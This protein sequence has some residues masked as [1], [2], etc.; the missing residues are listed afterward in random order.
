MSGF[1]EKLTAS[2]RSS[3]SMLCVGLDPDPSRLPAVVS[4][5]PT[6]V[7]EFNRQIVDATI[8]LVCAYKP[9][10]A[11]YSAFG[12]ESELEQTIDYIKSLNPEIP[13]ILDAKRGDIGS[14]AEMYAREAFERYGADAVTVNPYMGGDTLEPFLKYSDRGV[15]VLCHTSNPGSGEFQD[16]ESEGRALYMA[17]AERASTAWNGNENVALVVGATYPGMLGEVRKQVGNMPILV[18][19]IGTQGGDIEQVLD[20][21][22]ADNGSGLVLNVARSII[23]AGNDQDFAMAAREKAGLFLSA[24]EQA[25][26]NQS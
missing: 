4:S 15:V 12:R 17:V 25:R 16:M 22:L 1:Y 7:F 6:P 2:W 18:P 11:F 26:E 10:V 14:T 24:I 5:S 8:D 9:Q 23:Y 3:G 19:G 21:G 13:V 20:Q